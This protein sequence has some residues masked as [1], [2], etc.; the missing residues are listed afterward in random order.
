MSA[1]TKDTVYVNGE[2]V[3]ALTEARLPVVN[4]ATGTVIGE[5][6][7]GSV[8]DVDRAVSAARVAFDSGPVANDVGH[9][10]RGPPQA[11]G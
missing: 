3:D 7:D 4:P 1:R 10:S 11:P 9:R 5:V 8:A 6:P 2:F